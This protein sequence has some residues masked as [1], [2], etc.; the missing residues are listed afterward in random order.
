MKLNS[1][2]IRNSNN[3]RRSRKDSRSC[4]KKGRPKR[5]L[6]KKQPL[7]D[8]R[9]H[10]LKNKKFRRVQVTRPSKLA[11][12][13]LEPDFP[14]EISPILNQDLKSSP[15][16]SLSHRCGLTSSRILKRRRTRPR[17]SISPGIIETQME[18]L[19]HSQF[20]M[21]KARPHLS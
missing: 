12:S 16:A 1:Q 2:R 21:S 15:R 10:K 19:V 9:S 5:E 17:S 4:K 7:K 13:K 8:K 3:R 14:R 11:T 20:P 6:I 18:R